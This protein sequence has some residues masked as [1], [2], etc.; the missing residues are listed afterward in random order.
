ME[1]SGT[2]S[3]RPE[4]GK[5]QPRRKKK[6]KASLW[7]RV[8]VIGLGAF[9]FILIFAIIGLFSQL[10]KINR[11]ETV[12]PVAV[13]DEY[14]ETEETAQ[15]EMIDPESVEWADNETVQGEDD[16]VN[17]LLIGQDRRPGETRARSDSMIIATANKTDQT[18]KLTSLMRDMY[19]QIPGYSDNRINAAYAFGGMELLDQTIKENFDLDIDGNIEVDFSG[20]EKVIDAIGGVDIELTT[21]EVAEINR[22]SFSAVVPAAGMQHLNGAQALAYARIRYIGN[23]DFGRT[24]RQRAILMAAYDKG[25]NMGM[26]KL[27]ELTDTLFPLIT[28]DQDNMALIDLG[29]DVFG[30]NVTEIEMHNIPED[31]A[32]QS[33][34]IRGMDVLVPDLDE[35]RRTLNDIIY[36][37]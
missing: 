24:G 27:L 9:F 31:A 15:Y 7:L 10:D 21:A 28:T 34:N 25:R 13:S 36:G 20:F 19:V 12:E 5:D 3:K 6:K 2:H 14:F 29:M 23:G 26:T 4:S 22:T 33:A 32:Y 30:M 37:D 18:I 1:K 17:I 16:I 11:A 8:L 35:C